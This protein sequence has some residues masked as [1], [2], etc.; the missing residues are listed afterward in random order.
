MFSDI[1]YRFWV[2]LCEAR[3][4]M[5]WVILV[6]PTKLDFQLR[7]DYVIL[8]SY[9]CFIVFLVIFCCCLVGF[10]TF[11]ELEK[12]QHTQLYLLTIFLTYLS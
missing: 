9:F 5:G 4:W 2:V 10:V 7:D 12:P 6:G 3:S 11:S 1:K 8:Q